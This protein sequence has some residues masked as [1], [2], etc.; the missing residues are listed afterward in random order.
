MPLT[1]LTGDI[2]WNLSSNVSYTEGTELNFTVYVY[3]NTLIARDY[4]LYAR[5]TRSGV[6]LSEFAIV[7]DDRSNFIIE[8]EE[9]QRIQ[10]AIVAEYTDAVLTIV[11]YDKIAKAEVDLVSTQLNSIAGIAPQ[12]PG[13][14]ITPRTTSSIMDTVLPMM[15]LMMMMVMM[16]KMIGG[17]K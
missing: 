1:G 9:I 4:I 13:T 15:M 8:A 17:V 10:C 6:L 12:M 16:T 2:S 5:V 7:I 14:N 11:L 3:N